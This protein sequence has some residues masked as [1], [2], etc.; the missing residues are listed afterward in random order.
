MA[1]LDDERHRSAAE[2]GL[3]NVGDV[4]GSLQQQQRHGQGLEEAAN[5][6]LVE[7]VHG[8]YRSGDDEAI[9]QVRGRPV[10][11]QNAAV[12]LQ[13]VHRADVV[14]VADGQHEV[15]ED[16]GKRRSG[17]L[18]ERFGEV[19]P[20]RQHVELKR[21]SVEETQEPEQCQH[22]RES[23]KAADHVINHEAH[24]RLQHV[25]QPQHQRGVLATDRQ[26]E[27]LNW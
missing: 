18:E 23:G 1:Q 24:H 10:A 11:Q 8:L 14:Q 4:E 13:R 21:L 3:C 5:R 16:D 17:D 25:L 19:G 22:A 6:R 26:P 7:Q 9:E 20:V 15:R 12:Q 2:H 27:V